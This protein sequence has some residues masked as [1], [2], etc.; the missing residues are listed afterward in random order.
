GLLLGIS[1]AGGCFDPADADVAGTEGASSSSATETG[2]VTSGSPGTTMEETSSTQTASDGTT[3]ATGDTT[4]PTTP[5][6]TG[7]DA[8][9]TE[10]D[11]TTG[12]GAGCADP[13]A[14]PG[15]NDGMVAEGDVCFAATPDLIRPGDGPQ[16]LA[17]G[18]IDND[19]H[20]DV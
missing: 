18:H 3:S 13:E 14:S 10:A 9:T 17:V 15:C 12:S 8:E 5:T 4:D 2:A 16:M 7:D 1:L 20:L 11:G 19:E 6:S